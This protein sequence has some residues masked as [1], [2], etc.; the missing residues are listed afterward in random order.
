MA[1]MCIGEKRKVIIP[2]ALGF[3]KEGRQSDSIE[4]GQTLY[5]TVQL[6]NIFR[7]VPGPT[8]TDD[9][10]LKIEVIHFPSN[11]KFF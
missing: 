1:G 2:S 3:G 7:P 9:D 6:V 5:Y 8:W 10:G 4:S 11:K